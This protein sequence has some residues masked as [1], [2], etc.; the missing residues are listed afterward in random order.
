MLFQNAPNVHNEEDQ[1]LK[2]MRFRGIEHMM[3]LVWDNVWWKEN[4]ANPTLE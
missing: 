2:M 4:P 3:R 1:L